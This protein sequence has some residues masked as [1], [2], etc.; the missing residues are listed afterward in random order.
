M[1]QLNNVIALRF[2]NERYRSEI[3]SFYLDGEQHQFTALPA[4]A[5]QICETDHE[6]YPVMVMD[7]CTPAGFFVLHEKE[8]VKQYSKN[9]DSILLR[10]YSINTPHQGKGIAKTSIKLLPS[11]VK[12]NFPDKN[13]IVLAVNHSNHA[14]QHVY[15]A[16]G[17]EDRGNRVMGKKGEQFIMHMDL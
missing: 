1:N 14:A 4:E 11:F 10:A 3:E 17:F 13:E 5:L 6:R 16:C 2:Y 12:E 7:G 8:G 15:K 9:Q